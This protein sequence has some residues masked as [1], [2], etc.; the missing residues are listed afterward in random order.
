ALCVV[1]T[2]LPLVTGK[3]IKVG[4]LLPM[5]GRWPIGTRI[6]AA[7]PLSIQDINNDITLLP[8]FNLTYSIHDSACVAEKG[9]RGMVAF[10]GLDFIIGPGCSLTAQPVATLAKIW[11]KPIITYAA[12]SAAFIDKTVFSTFATV[13]AYGRRNQQYTPAFVARLMS[14][15]NWTVCGILTSTEVEWKAMAQKIRAL[16]SPLV[17]VTVYEE[18]DPQTTRF[19]EILRRGRE[20]ARVFLLLCYVNQV[21]DIMRAAKNLGMTNGDHAFVTIDLNTDVFYSNGRWTGNDGPGSQFSQDLNG[22]VDLSVDRPLLS[23]DFKARYRAMGSALVPEVRQYLNAKPSWYAA[24]LYDAIWLAALALN[25]TI[26]DGYDVTNTSATVQRMFNRQFQGESG[27][28][29][30]INGTRV[31]LFAVGNI[32]NG[33][34]KLIM[35]DSLSQKTV[36]GLNG[37][38]WPGQ[39][40]TVPLSVPPCGFDGSFCINKTPDGKSSD[41]TQLI[42]FAVLG[43]CICLVVL[44]GVAVFLRRRQ[45]QECTYM[46]WVIPY[47]AIAPSQEHEP[48]EINRSRVSQACELRH[49]NVNPCVGV[50]VEPLTVCIVNEFC[51]K[52]SLQDILLDDNLKLDWTFKMSF[53]MDIARGMEEIHKSAIG[54]HGRLKSKNVV[55]DSY[56][57]CKIADYGLGSIRQSQ[58][59]L[60]QDGKAYS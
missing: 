44:V 38:E 50:C 12:S 11:N 39:G 13:T 16:I 18:H 23:E 24:F 14:A 29:R 21:T 37:I 36:D 59:D 26:A 46:Q 52:G 9:L 57:I 7:A 47:K 20:N 41:E 56:W 4:I 42:I 19:D 5:T 32:V 25:D 22:I 17:N 49:V 3:E 6:A 54:P 28:V 30:M 15:F 2:F 34:Y 35:N 27:K 58:N 33:S 45:D 43:A 55:V 53:A 8:A 48:E 31:P 10:E 51:A 40:R 60:G 1:V